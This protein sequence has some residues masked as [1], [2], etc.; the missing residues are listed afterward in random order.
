MVRPAQLRK[1]IWIFT[2]LSC[3]NVCFLNLRLICLPWK[4]KIIYCIILCAS[5]C[6]QQCKFDLMWIEMYTHI[7]Y[8]PGM[9]LLKLWRPLWH[10]ATT[11]SPP[12]VKWESMV[13]Y[14]VC[15]VFDVRGPHHSFPSD[16]LRSCT[17]LL[18][19]LNWVKIWLREHKSAIPDI[20]VHGQSVQSG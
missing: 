20:L 7:Y 14:Q 12:P 17:I 18:I 8:L 9:I 11:W 3:L 4:M 15:I 1:L 16:I 10:M 19:P 2:G 13:E 6:L 5:L